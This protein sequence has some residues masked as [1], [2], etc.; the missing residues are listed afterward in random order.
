MQTRLQIVKS[1]PCFPS[2]LWSPMKVISHAGHVCWFDPDCF[3]AFTPEQFTPG[4]W[5]SREWVLGQSRGRGITWFVQEPGKPA[6][7][8]RHYWRGG[9]MGRLLGDRF[10]LTPLARSR[11]MAEFSLLTRLRELGLPVPKPAAA[12]RVRHGLFYRA[13]LLIERIPGARD[14]VQILRERPLT[15]EEWRAIGQVI[16][17]LHQAGAYHSDLNAHNLLLDGDDQIWVIDFDKCGLRA[18]G[19]W[20]AEMLARL[21]RSLRKEAGL[22]SEFHWQE[23]DWMALLAGYETGGVLSEKI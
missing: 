5:Q 4:W 21:L 11:A 10:W 8:L 16:R 20:Q 13:D 7:V 1:W 2:T 12:R 3:S 9:L 17:Q 15:P 6:L 14:L 22:H 18:P 23:A 19:P